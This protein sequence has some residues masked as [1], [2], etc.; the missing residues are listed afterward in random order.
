MPEYI[1]GAKLSEEKINDIG[2]R[3]DEIAKLGAPYLTKRYESEY[4]KQLKRKNMTP[5][6]ANAIAICKLIEENNFRIIQKILG[7][8][9]PG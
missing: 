3:H 9:L 7:I 1:E 8:E 2:E 6:E 4:N 5:T